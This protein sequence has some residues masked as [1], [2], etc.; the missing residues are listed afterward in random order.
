ME[1]EQKTAHRAA[2]LSAFL[3]RCLAGYAAMLAVSFAVVMYVVATDESNFQQV[4]RRLWTTNYYYTTAHLIL[5]YAALPFLV[6]ALM[7]EGGMLLCRDIL[8]GKRSKSE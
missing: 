1:G 6:A 2:P 7:G 4:T 8:R 3:L 5:C